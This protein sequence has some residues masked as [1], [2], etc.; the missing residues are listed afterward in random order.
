M[1]FHARKLFMNTVLIIRK[2]S[3]VRPFSAFPD[4][5]LG[6]QEDQ[7]SDE[8]TIGFR[9]SSLFRRNTYYSDADKTT[10]FVLL[11]VCCSLK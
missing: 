8:Y 10:K 9:Y 4:D 2:L 7:A 6:S 11:F 3:Y 1:L 5:V